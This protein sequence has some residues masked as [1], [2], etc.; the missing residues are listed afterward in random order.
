MVASR[1]SMVSL[2]ML[3]ASIEG[4]DFLMNNPSLTEAFEG[5]IRSDQFPCI[6]AKSAL[7]RDC[8]TI[9]EADAID[10][11]T[12]DLAVHAALQ[13]FGDSLDHVGTSIQS[14]AVVFRRPED[15]SEVAFEKA[16]WNRLQSLH[17]LDVATGE[18]WSVHTS[19]DPESAHFCMSI[20]TNAYFI[21]GLR[22]HASR[23][24]RRFD[25]PVMVFNSHEQFEHLR[26][27]GRYDKMRSVIRKR[28]TALA[29]DINPMLDDFGQSSEA[30]QY[31]G[32]EVGPDWECPFEP[33]EF[34]EH[35]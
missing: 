15:L 31:S 5:F 19:R 2:M 32:R 11:S 10:T 18:P 6:G 29:S 22:P 33:K 28:D 3:I 14:F 20:G 27:D 16:L 4:E 17:N 34:A 9:I 21:V 35:D 12:S 24:A 23:P 26:D 30:R 8:M 7:V 1:N 25:Y 13:K